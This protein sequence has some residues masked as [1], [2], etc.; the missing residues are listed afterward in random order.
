MQNANAQ[1]GNIRTK[2]ANDKARHKRS[3]IKELEA[4]L[5]ASPEN[6]VLTDLSSE[7][8]SNDTVREILGPTLG[9]QAIALVETR[10]AE[11]A[12]AAALTSEPPSGTSNEQ[13]ATDETVTDNRSAPDASAKADLDL[14]IAKKQPPPTEQQET[15]TTA[16]DRDC[17]LPGDPA[18][19]QRVQMFS[20]LIKRTVDAGGSTEALI[21]EMFKRP[22]P[23]TVVDTSSKA[24]DDLSEM[25]SV[26]GGQP[27]A[28]QQ[29]S[30]LLQR[31]HNSMHPTPTNI[32]HPKPSA[33]PYGATPSLA[34]LASHLLGNDTGMS[35][36]LP[37]RF[38]PSLPCILILLY[39][40]SFLYSIMSCTA[41][42]RKTRCLDRLKRTPIP[43]ASGLHSR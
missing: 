30:G 12:A 26:A 9:S 35:Y 28:S 8:L 31:L 41:Q 38:T 43:S 27:V 1:N 40:L 37:F 33:L 15:S 17:D 6:K 20:R 11:K 19:E 18:T 13:A 23:P 4:F 36:L 24:Q 5:A 16:Q 39:E 29:R 21:R 34:G 42:L 14:P 32:Q 25:H 7:L 3:I 2:G 10:Q 22:E